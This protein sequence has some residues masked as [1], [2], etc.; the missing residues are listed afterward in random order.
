M[1]QPIKIDET[2]LQRIPITAK[3][4]GQGNR[5][6]QKSEKFAFGLK[7]GRHDDAS[8]VGLRCDRRRKVKRDHGSG[9]NV[10]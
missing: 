8:I 3:I 9:R 5:L 6:A 7:A 4:I 1:L 10:W 2:F